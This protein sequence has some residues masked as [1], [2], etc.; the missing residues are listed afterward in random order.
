MHAVFIPEAV[1]FL[2]I[3]PSVCFFPLAG[4]SGADTGY[5]VK[6]VKSSFNL[7]VAFCHGTINLIKVPGSRFRGIPAF[8]HLAILVITNPLAGSVHVL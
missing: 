1:A 2:R 3:D 6:I 4:F 7:Y 8:Y 5:P